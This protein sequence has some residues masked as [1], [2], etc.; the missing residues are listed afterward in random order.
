MFLRTFSGFLLRSKKIMDT[1]DKT[2]CEINI[3][4]QAKIKNRILRIMIELYEKRKNFGSSEN[5]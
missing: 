2:H 4:L 5:A 3:I 1:S